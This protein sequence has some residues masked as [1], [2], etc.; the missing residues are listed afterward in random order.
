M[1]RYTSLKRKT[2]LRPRKRSRMEV[3]IGKVTGKVRLRG[4]A[5][6][7]L[8]YHRWMLDMRRCVVCGVR[9]FWQARYE[10]DPQAYGLAHVTSRGASGGDTLENTRT[11]CHSCH[12][13]EHTKGLNK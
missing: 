5:L 9:T 12:M 10:G 1:N 3:F 2:P 7:D 8:R 4:K 13:Q 6:A 11:K